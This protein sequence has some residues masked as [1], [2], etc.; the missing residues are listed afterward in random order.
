MKNLRFRAQVFKALSDPVRLKILEFLRNGEKCV[1]EIV[2]HVGI[3]QPLVSRHLAI[4]KRCGLVK[5]RQYGNRRFYSITNPAIYRVIDAVNDELLG[6]LVK[7][8]VEQIA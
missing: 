1:C 6:A 2:P 7:H 3:S 4:L 8:V 5:D